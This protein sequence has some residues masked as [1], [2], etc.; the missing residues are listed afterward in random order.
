MLSLL[1]AS[2]ESGVNVT[3][4]TQNP[5]AALY[6]NSDELW[7][8]IQLI[9]HSGVEVILTDS[10]SEH[11]AVM[12]GKLVWYG[13]MNPLGREDAWDNLIRVDSIQAAAELL[14][15]TQEVWQKEMVTAD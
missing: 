10:A 1:A 8:L 7:M 12:D 2:Q 11:Y 15:M 4:V 6:D 5:D 9:R 14:E 3:V 13:G